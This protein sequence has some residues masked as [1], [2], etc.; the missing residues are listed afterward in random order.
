MTKQ[1]KNVLGGGGG[2]GGQIDGLDV[3]YGCGNDN[4][5]LKHYCYYLL[6]HLSNK[7]NL[8]EHALGVFML[9]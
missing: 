4:V 5:V 1:Q 6:N 3:N 8:K 7:K 2:V 9:H